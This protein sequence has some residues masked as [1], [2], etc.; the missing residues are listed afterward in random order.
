MFSLFA[1]CAEVELLAK[2]ECGGLST[3]AA[4]CA[5]SGRDDVLLGLVRKADSSATLRNGN[6]NGCVNGN[7]NGCVN[8]MQKVVAAECLWS[9]PSR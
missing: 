7:V 2:G 1:K 4:E 8:G 5:A 6:V 9:H 3:A